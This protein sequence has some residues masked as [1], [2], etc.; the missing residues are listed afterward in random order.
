MS[1]AATYIRKYFNKESK[2]EAFQ[3]AKNIQ[4]EFI[5]MLENAPWMDEQSREKAIEKA[6]TMAL[7]IGYPDE[8]DND[9]KLE[10]YYRDLELQQNSL[11]HSVLSIRKFS[12]NKKI[13]EF[14]N[15]I[16][17]NDW[18]DIAV[19]AANVDAYYHPAMN[20]IS[21]FYRE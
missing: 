11:L 13:H 9:Q 6:N 8:M 1:T 15:S 4:K 18:R 5:E 12:R 3:L 17:K 2:D 7:N 16:L 20:S 10:E 21:K 19:L 14:R